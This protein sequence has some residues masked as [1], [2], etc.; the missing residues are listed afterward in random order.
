MAIN[1][2]N[3]KMLQRLLLGCSIAVLPNIAWAH[4]AN[5]IVFG[6]FLAGMTH[7]VLGT[8]H[9]LA[10][11]SVGI[12]SAQIGGR[13]LW[14]MPLTFV[15]VMAIGGSL[16]M[17]NTGL[18]AVEAG[19]AFSLLALGT[20]IA[21]DRKLPFLLALT[22]VGFFAIFHG[23]AHGAEIP[24]VAKPISY[25]LGFMAG[26]TA[27]HILGLIIGDISQ[28]Y[29]KGKAIL[30]LGGIAIAGFGVSLAISMV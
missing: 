2:K 7:P 11:V 18:S 30:R 14:T 10:M 23:Y 21:C 24:G 26:T 25:A 29:T 22:A 9:F 13:A 27:L 15:C 19:I 8:D 12:L 16:G 4:E 20:A 17:V 28:H 1:N 6:S 3:K 5:T